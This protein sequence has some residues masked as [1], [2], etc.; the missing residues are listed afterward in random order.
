M[1]NEK[2]KLAKHEKEAEFQTALFSEVKEMRLRH[3]E[4]AK[5]RAS[6]EPD[7]S[8]LSQEEQRVEYRRIVDSMPPR[9]Q[10]PYLQQMPQQVCEVKEAREKEVEEI[11]KK[12]QAL[13]RKKAAIIAGMAKY[14]ADIAE[15][16]HQ[17]EMAKYD[18]M[19]QDKEETNS[20][21]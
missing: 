21:D 14:D 19:E 15:A 18:A 17:E 1:N 2:L 4:V 5:E 6:Q 7:Y 8:H 10:V 13:R 16:V 3:C 20:V 9:R 12:V 11:E